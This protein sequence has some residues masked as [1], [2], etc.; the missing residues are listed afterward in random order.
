MTP[1]YLKQ[2]CLEQKAY[3]TPELNDKI[4]LHFKG[5]SEIQNLE[6]YVGL[7]ALWLEGNGIGQIKNLDQL[8]ELRCFLINKFTE[9]LDALVNLDTLNIANN[10]IKTISGISNLHK[11]R[12]LQ[13]DHNYLRTYQDISQLLECQ[14]LG[15][16]DISFNHLDDPEIIH[17]FEQMT[18]LTVLNIMSNPVIPKIMNYRRTMV[19]RLKKLTYLD[20][21]P[22]FDKERLAT[23]AWA[24]GGMEAEREEKTRQREEERKEHD[25]NFEALKKLQ[26]EA[27]AKRVAKYGPE[28]TNP[29]FEPK[30]QVLHDEMLNKLELSKAPQSVT[31]ENE[32]GNSRIEQI[33]AAEVNLLDEI[34]A[35]DHDKML[36]N[37]QTEIPKINLLKNANTDTKNKNDAFS[38]EYFSFNDHV[39]FVNNLD[40]ETEIKDRISVGKNI[41]N[42]QTGVIC[43]NV[44][45]NNSKEKIQSIAQ[46]Q[47][48][49]VDIPDLEEHVLDTDT[50]IAP[51]KKTL[52]VHAWKEEI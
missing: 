23:E 12:T 48:D 13:I 1:K 27:R 25:R 24:I 40:N 45:L 43:E 6:P 37:F 15:V 20:D 31:E 49:E 35:K 2:I 29:Q 32:F 19:S 18:E 11:L 8:I 30:L 33:T 34:N 36:E 28:E 10:L 41:E 44:I 39:S 47:H 16:L 21:R 52:S 17:I 51:A 42:N 5:F 3:A 50:V 14:S 7:K 46:G 38:T 4:Y 22:V 26:E 9:N